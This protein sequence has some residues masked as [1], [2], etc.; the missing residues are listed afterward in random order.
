V[1]NNYGLI[2]ELKTW[3]FAKV[4]DNPVGFWQIPVATIQSNP[5]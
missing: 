4:H 5:D 1:P 2:E 3:A